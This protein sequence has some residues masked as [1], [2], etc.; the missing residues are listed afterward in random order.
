METPKEAPKKIVM[1]SIVA[2][3]VAKLDSNLREQFDERAGIME[4]DALLPRRH[5]EALALIDVIRR[6]PA[7]LTG[8]T[9][10]QVEL[11]GATQWLL[12]ADS[13]AA[14]HYLVDVGGAEI[15]EC[16]LADVLN[17]QYGGLAMLATAL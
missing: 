15:S 13:N 16:D 11:D 7:V 8:I 12:S 17:E 10:L 2:E 3:L 9:V 4:F 1:D 5:A 6:Y 14:R